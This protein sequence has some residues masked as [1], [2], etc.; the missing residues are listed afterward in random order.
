[1]CTAISWAQR[2]HYFGRTLD[3]EQSFGEQVIIT[4]RYY[5]LQ[6]RHL[7][8]Q[9]KHYAIIGMAVAAQ[10]A[11]LY[12]DAVN[13]MGLCVAA[14]NF[15]SLCQYRPYRPGMTAVASYEVIGW[16][17]GQC[18]GLEQAA[19][20]LQN[21]VITGEAFSLEYAPTPLHWLVADEH[22]SLVVESTAKGVE[23]YQGCGVLTNSPEYP[24]QLEYAAE[25]AALSPK[26]PSTQRGMGSLGLPGDFTSQGRFVRADFLK[27][28]CVCDNSEGDAVEQFFHMM[29]LVSQPR[30]CV[31]TD[32][33]ALV[34]TQYTSCCNTDKG[35]YYYTTSTNRR[36]CGVDL[37]GADLK[38]GQLLCYPVHKRPD[39]RM[40]P[41]SRL[42][43]SAK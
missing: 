24:K 22:G 12:F 34:Q 42:T 13:E 43:E 38:G 1:M 19:S 25:F 30:G 27:K 3:L 36:I 21:C 28:H 4:P 2:D 37:H 23:I 6:F 16:V 32:D 14:L 11:P 26:C 40:E 29:E 18:A 31:V 41:Q 5:P 15:P 7:P 17:L 8:S 20:L 10:G 9:E 39:F 35:I 33:G